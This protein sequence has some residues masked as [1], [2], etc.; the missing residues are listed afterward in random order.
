MTK[1][2]EIVINQDRVYHLGL[3]KG[4]LA[5][6][7]FLVGDPARAY[8]VAEHFDSIEHQV[9]N[10]E[11]ITLTGLLGK[12]PVSVIGTGIGTDNVEIAL[13]EAYI[14]HEFD[15]NT[16]Q[17]IPVNSPLNFIRIGTSGGVQEHIAPGTMGIS[18]YAL[19]LDSTG[20][21]YE[22]P[23]ADANIHLIEQKAHRILDYAIQEDYRFKGKIA[24]YASKASD[25][26]VNA[27]TIRASENNTDFVTG[28][29]VSSPGFYG[30]SA[31]YID[32]LKNSVPDIKTHLATLSI[33][34][35]QIINMEMESSLLFHLAGCLGYTAGTICPIISNP[36]HSDTIVD[37][38]AAIQSAIK[39]G[40]G[41][42]F[43]L[44]T[45]EV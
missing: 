22:S 15:F 38:D 20:I 23:K 17:K 13:V 27:L 24:P 18:K 2:S 44:F 11:Y 39:I 32:G 16:Q 30:P 45:N 21:Y 5:P 25:K 7:I 12:M 37:Y 26:I 42:M 4:Q 40:I 36:I 33:Q 9:T 43:D 14:V 41:A 19:G 3:T 10:R 28:I 31:R 1:R 35:M 34:E 6:Y 8:K 29:T